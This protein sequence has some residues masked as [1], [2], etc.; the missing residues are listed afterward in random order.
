MRI[1]SVLIS[2]FFVTQFAQAGP[3]SDFAAKTAGLKIYGENGEY[4]VYYGAVL[5]GKDFNGK[6][7]HA[8]LALAFTKVDPVAQQVHYIHK[9]WAPQGKAR[10]CYYQHGSAKTKFIVDNS[11]VCTPDDSRDSRPGYAGNT[12]RQ[13]GPDVMK[14]LPF[15]QRIVD[16]DAGYAGQWTRCPYFSSS[17]SSVTSK[18]HSRAKLVLGGFNDALYNASQAVAAGSTDATHAQ[19]AQVQGAFVKIHEKALP[20][21]IA[22]GNKNYWGLAGLVA[23]GQKADS[24]ANY[25]FMTTNG[26]G[27]GLTYKV[28]LAPMETAGGGQTG[29]PADDYDSGNSAGTYY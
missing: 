13:M 10:K 22:K 12:T 29:S 6:K 3:I 20:K 17:D 2:L 21:A 7:I 18:E 9:M 25:F 15:G 4:P 16:F 5:S 11:T 24:K 23:V 1:L 8:C 19:L 28:K 27:Y 26:L 14:A